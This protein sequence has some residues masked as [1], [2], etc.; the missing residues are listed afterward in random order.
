MNMQ[1]PMICRNYSIEL[2]CPL[3]PEIEFHAQGTY[4]TMWADLALCYFLTAKLMD[5]I[6]S[7]GCLLH[8]D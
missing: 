3:T 2:P 6:L 5:V 7:A 4:A 1:G 8:G